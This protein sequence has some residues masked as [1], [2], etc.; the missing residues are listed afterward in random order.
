MPERIELAGIQKA[1]TALA[2]PLWKASTNL[3]AE[4]VMAEISCESGSAALN[5]RHAT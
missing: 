5:G 1:P 4:S 3:F 2:S